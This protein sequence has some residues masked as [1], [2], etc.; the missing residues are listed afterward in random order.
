MTEQDLK[1]ILIYGLGFLAIQILGFFFMIEH[2]RNYP[3]D[4]PT[5]Q[6]TRQLIH[7]KSVF[8]LKPKLRQIEA[9]SSLRPSSL[10]KDILK[11]RPSTFD[12]STTIADQKY[13]G[14]YFE[15]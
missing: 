2:Y 15:I 1:P 9:L 10:T 3:E 5:W 7:I 11:P 8:Y 6:N 4:L 14:K 13:N 12:V